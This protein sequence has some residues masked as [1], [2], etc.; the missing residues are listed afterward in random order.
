MGIASV[1]QI[2]VEAV[3]RIVMQVAAAGLDGIAITEHGGIEFG[4]RARQI[5]ER[6]L[7]ASILILPGEEVWYYPLEIVQILLPDGKYLRFV[8]HPGAPGACERAVPKIAD[9]LAG[10]EISNATHDWHIDRAMV[11]TLA[12]RHNLMLFENSDAHNLHEIGCRFNE[13]DLTTLVEDGNG[14]RWDRMF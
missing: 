12:A 7:N 2:T 9:A 5:A 1:E 4:L 13:L 11:Q 3:E 10:I 14:K 8:A 6:E